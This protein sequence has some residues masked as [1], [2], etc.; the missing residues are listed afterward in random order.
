MLQFVACCLPLFSQQ[1]G[2]V[3]GPLFVQM[4]RSGLGRACCPVGLPP[5]PKDW[6]VIRNPSASDKDQVTQLRCRAA[7]QVLLNREDGSD[8]ENG[9]TH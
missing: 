8:A 7:P 3:C 2:D 5:T 4:G 6:L 1:H 9:F